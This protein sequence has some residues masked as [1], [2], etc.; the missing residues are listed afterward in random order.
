MSQILEAFQAAQES[1]HRRVAIRAILADHGASDAEI[2]ACRLVRQQRQPIDWVLVTALA[3]ITR[4]I[5]EI[6]Q[7]IGMS[8]SSMRRAIRL[9]P[10][11]RHLFSERR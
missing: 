4:D 1:S 10:E 9:W 6:A 11:H 8:E 2:Q 5:P 7:T 3:A